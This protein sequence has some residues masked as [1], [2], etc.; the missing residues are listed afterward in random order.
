MNTNNT[1]ARDIEDIYELS[2]MQQGML[3]HSLSSSDAQMYFEQL[4]WTLEGPLDVT[5]FRRAWELL[6]A[7]HPV[8][9]TSFHWE[10]LDKPLQVVHKCA[11]LPLFYEDWS[12]LSKTEQEKRLSIFR[13]ADRRREW[14]FSEA[15]LIR[16]SL[17]RLGDDLHEFI[18][19]HHHILLD[20]WS[21]MLVLKEFNACY[22][23]GR[24]G[25]THKA[26]STRQYRDYINWLQRQDR[27][28]SEAYWR[29]TWLR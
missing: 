13:N 14:Q 17:I 6:I 1:N 2:P 12:D 29:R 22:E 3:F 18:L 15:P 16:L 25:I 8:L 23:A 4:S 20:G 5:A 7:R 9:R 19:G 28:A 26:E 21:L 27:T 24:L 10:G 11:R